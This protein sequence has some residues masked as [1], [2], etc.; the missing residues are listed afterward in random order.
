MFALEYINFASTFAAITK[1]KSFLGPK[2]IAISKN[3]PA[4]SLDITGNELWK[5][6]SSSARQ[7][8][9]I[10]NTEVDSPGVAWHDFENDV[11]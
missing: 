8:P 10:D 7:S 11:R 1:K 5:Q 2:S 9:H 3:I 4:I 6:C